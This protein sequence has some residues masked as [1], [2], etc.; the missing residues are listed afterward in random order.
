MLSM[1]QLVRGHA[2]FEGGSLAKKSTY[3]L[4]EKAVEQAHSSGLKISRAMF[5]HENGQLVSV[6]W[7]GAVLYFYGDRSV[8]RPG[9]DP[10]PE[11]WLPN[12][13]DFLGE[14]SY[15]F[16]RFNCG[17]SLGVRRMTYIVEKDGKEIH[18]P[19]EV[20]KRGFLLAKRYGLYK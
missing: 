6:C 9:C 3:D 4:I 20:S 12:F 10:L 15:F 1:D 16:W 5:S 17:F 8:I 7:V 19:D 11:S 2:N 18:V 13:L 14:D